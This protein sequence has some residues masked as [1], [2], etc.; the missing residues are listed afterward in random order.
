LFFSPFWRIGSCRKF[1]I[2]MRLPMFQIRMLRDWIDDQRIVPV[3][4]KRDELL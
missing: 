2:L 1:D 3:R 4:K